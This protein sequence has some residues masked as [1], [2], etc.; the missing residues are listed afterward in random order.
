MNTTIPDNADGCCTVLGGLSQMENGARRGVSEMGAKQDKFKVLVIATGGNLNQTMR[1]VPICQTV[2][3]T[4]YKHYPYRME[5]MYVVG[6]SPWLR[7][8]FEA[9]LGILG[10]HTRKKI[11]IL[12]KL[13]EV[14]GRP[15]EGAGGGMSRSTS[16]GSLA[17][18]E[19]I[20][21]ESKALV[22]NIVKGMKPVPGLSSNML[23][24]VL[25]LA[26]VAA[27]LS[28]PGLLLAPMALA[29]GGDVQL[30]GGAQAARGGAAMPTHPLLAQ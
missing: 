22:T 7:I 8:G 5:H 29:A 6:L 16:V 20:S 17:S 18:L 19:L 10:A 13:S 12:R 1:I 15:N 25:L 3:L 21:A 14:P 24:A 4:I 30:G 11:K 26:L 23:A 28:N 9:V 2:A 27:L